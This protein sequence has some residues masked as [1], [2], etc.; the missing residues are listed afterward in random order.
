[1]AST[2]ENIIYRGLGPSLGCNAAVVFGAMSLVVSAICIV[3]VL[4]PVRHDP[5]DDDPVV[6]I[7][8]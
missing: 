8:R 5:K 4:L 6:R 1:M 2:C 7:D 3:R